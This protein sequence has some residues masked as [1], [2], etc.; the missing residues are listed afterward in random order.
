M[1]IKQRTGARTV[2][3]LI[4]K[5]NRLCQTPG[6]TTGVVTILGSN[7]QVFIFLAAIEALCASFRILAT[8]DGNFNRKD[9]ETPSGADSEDI[10]PA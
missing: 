4:M 9:A 1:A 6:F 3:N 2:L 5:M 8:I 7:D 10:P